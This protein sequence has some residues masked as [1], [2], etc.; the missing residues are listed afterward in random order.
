MKLVY[1]NDYRLG[2]VNGD[3]V[4]DVTDA[5]PGITPGD[6]RGLIERFGE[7]RGA[8]EQAAS[9]GQGVPLSSVKLQA[10][11]PRPTSIVCMAVNYRDFASGDKKPPVNAFLKSPT[12]ILGP[13]GVM[14]LPDAPASIFEGEAEFALVIGK[15]AV[16]VS[17]AEAMDYVFGYTNFVDGSA[18]G[19][20]P[21]P[22]DGASGGN[23]FYQMKSRNTFAPIGP[24][25]VTAD[26]VLDPHNLEVRLWNSGEL[27]QEYSSGGM[28]TD[29]PHVIE[30]V[31]AIHP[32]EA[33]D[34]VALGTHHNGLHA[35]QDG[36]VIEI[37]TTGLGRLRFTVKDEL[38]RSWKRQSRIA[39]IE[40]GEKGTA[41]QESGKYAQAGA[42]A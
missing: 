22:E 26:E 9:S 31:S 4:V 18:R 38:K 8:I 33:G 42:T 24:Y 23:T 34:I 19:L 37:E 39:R 14:E 10:P 1:F 7:L 29:I 13:E 3:N 5:V 11:V 36:D 15:R 20:G 16:N 32:L 30:F 6:S 27:M 12:A 35:F 25:L 21:N 40:A 28:W 17:A 2:V 41:P